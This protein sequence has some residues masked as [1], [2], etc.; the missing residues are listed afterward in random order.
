VK[1]TTRFKILIL[2]LILSI[3]GAVTY[4]AD[5]IPFVEVSGGIDTNL[6]LDGGMRVVSQPYI[7]SII[8]GDVPDHTFVTV[9]GNNPSVNT[10]A[11]VGE[12]IIWGV[13]P[14][15]Q[16][17]YVYPSAATTIDVVSTDADDNASGTGA[18]EVTIIGLDTNY[19]ELTEAI[20]THATDGTIAVTTTSE[21]LRV[22]G[23][24]VT[25]A[26]SSNFNEGDITVLDGANILSFVEEGTNKAIVAVY[27]VPANKTLFIENAKGTGAGTK[28]VHIHVYKRTFGGLFTQ[29]KHRTINDSPFEMTTFMF[30]EKTDV[31]GRCHSDINGGISDITLEGWIE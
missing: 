23:V 18:R 1:I 7:T 9:E 3:A 2:C 27:T 6:M 13:A 17:Q 5:G 22:N 29:E 19:A 25:S 14:G 28:N 4:A 31:E 8:E 15:T 21:F 26:G 16:A 24:E 12:Q 11:S 30:S 20:A 10:E